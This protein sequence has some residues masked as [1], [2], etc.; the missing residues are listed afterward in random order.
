MIALIPYVDRQL[1]IDRARCFDL[2]SR[3]RDAD[4]RIVPAA[5]ELCAHDIFAPGKDVPVRIGQI[6][7][8]SDTDVVEIYSTA[9]GWSRVHELLNSVSTS[10]QRT[11]GRLWSSGGW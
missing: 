7:H 8:G 9:A 6:Y 11:A 10:T 5:D 3:L 2:V 1:F 4:F